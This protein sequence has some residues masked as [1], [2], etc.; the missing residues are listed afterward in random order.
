MDA[1][2]SSPMYHYLGARERAN[3][4]QYK[5]SSGGTS[6][7]TRYVLA[8]YWNWLVTLVPLS[9]APN[10]LTLSGLLLVFVNF[11]MLLAA[12]GHLDAATRMRAHVMEHDGILPT[13]PL[14]PE[15][16]L[17]KA[18]QSV[19]P[20]TASA[21]PVWMLWVWSACLFMYQSLDAIDGKQARRTNMSGPLGELF[22]H[23]CDAL[24]TTLES[25]L[26][27]A[28]MGLGRSYWTL[29]GLT[30]A[31]TNFF[32]T[33]WE[34]Y[35]THT[36]FLSSF[37]G[38]VE[39]IVLI[40]ALYLLL[41]ALG[42]VICVQGFLNVTGLAHI[43]WV[44][45]NLAFANVPLGDLFMLFSCLGLLLNA[46]TGYEHVYRRCVEE[47]RSALMPL[48]GI[49]PFA[50]QT[51]A[52]MA[53]AMGHGAQVMVH[54]SVFVPFLLFWGL[55]FAYLVGLVI[56]AHVCHTPYPYWNVLLLPSLVLAVDAHLPQPV[57][58]G[59]L[60]ALTN[61]VYGSLALSFAVYAYFVYDVVT[62]I[63]KETG[64]PCLRVVHAHRE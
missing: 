21:V 53:W 31:M 57:L 24:N 19:Q 29:I 30:S 42:P 7:L 46:W 15:G 23:G 9:I 41:V 54:G 56:L 35:H 32:L 39:G 11:I 3:L 51:V 2:A 22:D 13:V 44:R 17:P 52:N 43:A 4:A 28:A 34:E 18:L 16:G 38:P 25:V 33:T 49:V 63:C 50:V 61:A 62:L 6:L 60:S 40:C 58:Q 55:S 36:L 27:C 45:E 12:D 59:S 64:K 47:K 10:M 48:V 37:S 1:R 26:V 14:L 20:S 8:P 5:Y